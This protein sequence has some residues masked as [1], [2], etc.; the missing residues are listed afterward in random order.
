MA[1]IL[2]SR[3]S[4]ILAASRTFTSGPFPASSSV[5]PPPPSPR[6]PGFIRGSVFG[7]L[8]G[9]TLSGGAAYVYLLD[10]YQNSSQSLLAS[11][12]DLQKSTNK[13]QSHTRKIE[14]VEKDLKALKGKTSTKDELE[15]LRNELLK[16][17]DDVHLSHL[18][19]KTSVWDLT[20]DVK[21]LKSK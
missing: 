3:T 2:R 9:L 12:E 16:V 10:D 20:Q 19:L 17:I 21:D 7:F 13:L 15:K 8:L 6:G 4:R 5:T 14:T 1:Y 11:V 18:E